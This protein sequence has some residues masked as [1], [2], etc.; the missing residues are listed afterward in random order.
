MVEK[1]ILYQIILEKK[2]NLT[3]T[4][5]IYIFRHLL[6]FIVFSISILFFYLVILNR[7]KDHLWALIGSL[8]LIVSPRIFADSFYNS[9]DLVFLSSCIIAIYFIYR[10]FDKLTLSRAILTGLFCAAAIGLRILGILLPFATFI[11]IF[12][13]A[14]KSGDI[15][16]YFTTNRKPII[17]FVLSCLI[18]TYVLFPFLWE[19]PVMNLARVFINMSRFRWYSTVTFMGELIDAKKLPFTYAPI[20]IAITTPPVFLLLFITGAIITIKQLF[21]SFPWLVNNSDS[22]KDLFA[23][24]LFFGPVLMII[25]LHSVIY[26]GWRHLYFIYP[27]LILIAI[28][29]LTLIYQ[30]IKKSAQRIILLTSISGIIGYYIYILCIL[31][32]YQAVYFNSFAGNTKF[33]FNNYDMDYWSLSYLRGLEYIVSHDT[34]SSITVKFNGNPKPY[35]LLPASDRKRIISVDSL[36]DATYFM[37]EYR[38]HPGNYTYKNEVHAEYAGDLKICSVFKMK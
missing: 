23:L 6:V 37:T 35:F 34:S 30:F 1:D 20:W 12:L 24:G 22:T 8:M 26:D 13:L 31:H 15:K 5:D 3:D 16:N 11:C 21:K 9:K 4:R 36:Y 14:G 18:F 7:H 33:V 10:F 25:F 38:K 2:L 17:G 19:N 29:A 28:K 27:A 32:P